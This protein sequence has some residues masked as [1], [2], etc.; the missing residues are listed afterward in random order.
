MVSNKI[1]SIDRLF[2]DYSRRE[3]RA[4]SRL[5]TIVEN[6]SPLYE[7]LIERLFPYLHSVPRMGITGPPGVGKSSLVS[8]IVGKF[9][10][11]GKTVGIIA[12]DPSSPFTGGAL[13]GDRIRMS[14]L[15]LDDGVFIRSLAT[16]GSMGGLSLA[17]ED[18][19]DLMDGF[20]CDIILI[21]TVGV[22][23]AELDIVKTADT[24]I[25]VLS[26][27]SG[28]SIQAM[29]AG[30][31]EIG[32][33]FVINKCDREGAD[34]AYIEIESAL[35]HKPDADWKT[36]IIKTSVNT[37][38]GIGALYQAILSHQRF[39]ND[40]GQIRRVRLERRKAKIRKIIDAKITGNFW[41]EDRLEA[42][43]KLAS[44]EISVVLAAQR[45]LN[46]MPDN[47]T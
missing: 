2:E 16:R 33:I 25:V 45:I 18:V 37:G 29:K 11:D 28:D 9:R 39:L 46:L 43:D 32:D 3:R 1:Y 24:T 40:K 8:E 21:E 7:E 20:G 17:T 6:G 4:L 34:R 19:A 42:L 23:Q 10:L 36:P 13:L 31:M 14:R 12:I 41:D 15:S 26:P 35:R 22:G 27:E 5:I 47:P 38:E 44:E 30:L